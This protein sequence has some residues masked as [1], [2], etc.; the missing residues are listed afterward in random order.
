MI[1]TG[2]L[3]AVTKQVEGENLKIENRWVMFWDT[4]VLMIEF[5]FLLAFFGSVL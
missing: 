4:V 1:I 2:K 5:I 3:L